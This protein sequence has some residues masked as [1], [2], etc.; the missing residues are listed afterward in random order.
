MSS[1][2]ISGDSSGTVTLAAPATAGSNTITL[3]AG[4]GT[5]TVAGVNSNIV[6]GTSQASTSGT[7]ITFSSIPSWAKR[8]TVMLNG[9]ST[10]GTS[11]IL[12]QIGAASVETTG[13]NSTTG[14]LQSG[15][16]Q[17]GTSATT[18][19]VIYTL[20]VA[21]T[22]SGIMVLTNISGSVWIA[23]GTFK[24]QTSTT[25]WM[26]GDKTITGTLATLA[27]TTADTFDAGSIN[28]LY[29]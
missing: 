14:Y 10:S 28:I 5:M 6:S 7:S 15:T 24:L 8:I 2:V 19:F 16:T 11:P 21:D 12:V 23:S 13:Y 27:V 29:E 20:S 26:G 4:T 22:K 3:P 9:V 17:N 25:A 1:V 18:G